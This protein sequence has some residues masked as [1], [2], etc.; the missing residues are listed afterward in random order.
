MA[1]LS[2]SVYLNYL[3]QTMSMTIQATDQNDPAR[4]LAD[5]TFDIYFNRQSVIT[6]ECKQ[7]V[8]L[9]PD[10]LLSTLIIE[11]M[12]SAASTRYTFPLLEDSGTVSL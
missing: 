8:L 7:S 11:L 9:D 10:P 5:A 1:T 6:S 2:K 4:F 12:Q 3:E